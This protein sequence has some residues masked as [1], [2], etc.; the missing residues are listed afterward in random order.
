M[1]GDA[2]ADLSKQSYIPLLISRLLQ[3]TKSFPEMNICA[4]QSRM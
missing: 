4:D 2:L 3:M 1:F